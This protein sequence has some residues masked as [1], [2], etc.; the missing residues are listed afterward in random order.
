MPIAEELALVNRRIAEV[1]GHILGQHQLIARLA[2]DG[3]DTSMAKALLRTMQES[4][5][6]LRAHRQR[7]LARIVG[8]LPE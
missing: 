3:L 2:A 1:E 6:V 5:D 7:L 8:K 4:R